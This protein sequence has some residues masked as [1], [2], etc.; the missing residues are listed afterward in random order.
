MSE[1]TAT[2]EERDDVAALTTC[3]SC[4]IENPNLVRIDSG[5]RLSLQKSGVDELP[6][7]V[8]S[9]CLKSL[10]K[11]ASLGA[12]ELAK[13]EI[14]AGHTGKLWKA[15]ISLVK[16]GHLLLQRGDYSEAAQCYEKYLKV[17]QLAVEKKSR[18][19]LDPSQF[20]D[21]PK[22]ITIICSVL[23]DLMLIYDANLKFQNR[24]LEAAQLLAQF[25]RFSPVYN[26]IVR[27][28]EKETHKAKNPMAFKTFL[29]LCD[30][31]TSRCFIANETFGS[32]IDPTVI[33]LCQ[34]RDGVLKEHP[35]GRKF[36]AFY[37][38]RSPAVAHLLRKWPFLKKPLRPLLRAL[39]QV[40]DRLF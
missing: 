28:A 8:C 24:Q 35:M 13:K 33:L 27:K 37:Y 19:E 1:E 5:L 31:H 34:F 12:Q 2:K 3:Q 38:K 22:E 30:A 15:R 29:K 10:R 40:T 9:P 25:V 17:L 39:A 23:W 18:A 36:V 4:G 7:F 21:H 20:H 26:T 14:K 11:S 32:R 16:Q 6:N